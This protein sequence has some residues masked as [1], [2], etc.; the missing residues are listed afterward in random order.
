MAWISWS[1]KIIERVKKGHSEVKNLNHDHIYK[2]SILNDI[3]LN[4]DPN[5]V[6]FMFYLKSKRSKIDIKKSNLGTKSNFNI[7]SKNNIVNS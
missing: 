4:F 5:Y 3:K 2:I 1:F 6:F 7:R